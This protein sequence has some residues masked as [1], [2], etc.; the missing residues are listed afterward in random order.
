MLHRIAPI[1][2]PN[3]DGHKCEISR[4]AAKH[5][6]KKKQYIALSMSNGNKAA[7]A[8]AR[9]FPNLYGFKKAERAR[10]IISMAESIGLFGLWV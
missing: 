9:A 5:W 4:R 3:Q 1:R 7:D 2:F 8:T 10:V 6:T